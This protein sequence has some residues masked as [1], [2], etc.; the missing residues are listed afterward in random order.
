MLLLEAT[1]EMIAA[2]S[3]RA[4]RIASIKF[5]S[6]ACAIAA[7]APES[8]TL[9]LLRRLPFTSRH[10]YQQPGPDTWQALH[11]WLQMELLRMEGQIEPWEGLLLVRQRAESIPK[12]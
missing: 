6:V 3:P 4:Y 7:K 8:V 11:W 1:S 2:E 5:C 10:Q 9:S 12:A